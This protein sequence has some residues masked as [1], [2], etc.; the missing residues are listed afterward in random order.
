M[1]TDTEILNTLE[2][3]GQVNICV[4]TR[5]PSRASLRSSPTLISDMTYVA[6]AHK[7]DV[8]KLLADTS[9]R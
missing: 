6:G 7:A 5:Q 2:W 4:R 8:E 3:C 1:L 9:T